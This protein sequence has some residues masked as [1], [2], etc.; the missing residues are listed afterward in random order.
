M[1]SSGLKAE[2]RT[3]QNKTKDSLFFLSACQT[4][5]RAYDPLNNYLSKNRG[6]VNSKVKGTRL[7][8]SCFS[9]RSVEVGELSFPSDNRKTVF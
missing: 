3:K 9:F 1:F 7:S 4:G 2:T 5:I 8:G 6:K